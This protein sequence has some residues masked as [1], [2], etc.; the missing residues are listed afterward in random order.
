MD[1]IVRKIQ[2]KQIIKSFYGQLDVN[3]EIKKKN[4][5]NLRGCKEKV[6]NKDKEMKSNQIKI[7]LL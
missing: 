6:K 2:I 1:R 4:D 7:W 3:N 5:E